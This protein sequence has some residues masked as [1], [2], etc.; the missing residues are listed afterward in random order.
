MAED[1][2]PGRTSSGGPL[3][4]TEAGVRVAGLLVLSLMTLRRADETGLQEGTERV[5]RLANPAA[6]VLLPAAFFRP[7]L[8]SGPPVIGI[9]PVG[10][11]L[12][13]RGARREGAA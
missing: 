1:C 9:G 3:S 11:P 6:A 8:P 2:E 4:E 12:Q 10:G 5:A 7:A 13:S